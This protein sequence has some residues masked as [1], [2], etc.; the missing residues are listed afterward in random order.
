MKKIT[1]FLVLLLLL[2]VSFALADDWSTFGHD[3]ARSSWAVSFAPDYDLYSSAGLT[4]SIALAA[5]DY[6][7]STPIIKNNVMYV[8]AGQ[9]NKDNVFATGTLYAF[10]ITTNGRIWSVNFDLNN[11]KATPTV[12]S[13]GATICHGAASTFYCRR[14]SDGTALWSA[15][16]TNAGGSFEFSPLI[17]NNKVWATTRGRPSMI[18]AFDLAKG[19][20]MLSK[21]ACTICGD[22]MYSP[23]LS[24]GT[25]YFSGESI[26]QASS[27]A[28]VALDENATDF[29]WV[30]P[31]PEG[32]N[33]MNTPSVHNDKVFIGAENPFGISGK[34]Y[35]LA[36]NAKDGSLLWRADL[37]VVGQHFIDSMPS[38]YANKVIIASRDELNTNHY[39]FAFNESSGE[40]LWQSPNIA[41]GIGG[42][43]SIADSKVVVSGADS[44][45]INV[46]DTLKGSL[47]WSYTTGDVYLSPS[48][49]NGVVY[50]GTTSAT[51]TNTVELLKSDTMY[52]STVTLTAGA[53][54][55]IDARAE[56][57]SIIQF[58]L[59]KVLLAKSITVNVTI[60]EFLQETKTDVGVS[61]L[62]K[63][64][65]ITVDDT[66]KSLITQYNIQIP[67]KIY[68]TDDELTA[69][70]ID[71]ASL[72]LYSVDNATGALTETAGSGVDKTQNYV[73]GNATHLSSFGSA[74]LIKDGDNDGVADFNDN[75]VS[76]A[77]SDQADS[78]QDG[79]GDACDNCI[80]AANLDQADADK[81]STGN[82]C[83]EDDDN[84]GFLDNA[85]N[86]KLVANAAQE[87]GDADG[88][89]DACDNCINVNNPTQADTDEDSHGNECDIC[90]TITG[91]Y[92]DD[93]SNNI[94]DMSAAIDNS[95]MA[96]GT[97]NSLTSKLDGVVSA[98]G[99]NQITNAVR[100][101]DSFVD[102]IS[103]LAK[104]GKLGSSS[105]SNEGAYFDLLRCADAIKGQILT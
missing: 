45:K 98:L 77:N 35:L 90:K 96:K 41:S 70:E 62:N 89:G 20:V 93:P 23:A 86:C 17:N 100:K 29:K 37:P 88:V 56:A 58:D 25:L 60:A 15:T 27:G 19:D 74:G 64:I 14:T 30:Y 13:D 82:A 38:V 33:I 46:F 105:S 101:L 54:T 92:Y 57:D 47:L 43:V 18:Y 31:L 39:V 4:E 61:Q 67:I 76:A 80:N 34:G 85:D 22:A 87:D 68:Y 71:E 75:C 53:V 5:G 73:Y 72:K 104:Q 21:T 83:D 103:R 2:N 44:G 78:D 99:R 7:E 8:V 69:A 11:P 63:Y 55:T 81:D 48:I 50:S 24:G 91:A 6:V 3:A 79:V 97:K 59:T 66:L 26:S 95:V 28:V 49:A 65:D 1:V 51:G 32:M 94:K 42:P 36:L 102:E 9:L 52:N 40:L 84:D 12:S 16:D 10:N